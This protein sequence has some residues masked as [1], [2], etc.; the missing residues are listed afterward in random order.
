MAVLNTIAGLLL[1]LCRRGKEPNGILCN[2]CS[3]G[4]DN[5]GNGNFSKTRPPEVRAK[6]AA[7]H[8]GK[9]KP[10]HTAEHNALISLSL[11]GRTFSSSHRANLSAATRGVK[12]NTKPRSTFIVKDPFDNQHTIH[13]KL[14]E[15][16]FRH[17]LNRKSLYNTFKKKLPLTIGK[18]A[19]WQLLSINQIF[20]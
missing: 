1:Q 12:H 5:T 9:P 6:I 13:G 2:R 19:G 10:K 14:N 11:K 3:V 20:Y 4:S 18:N 15:F 8:I 7:G 17:G 16:C